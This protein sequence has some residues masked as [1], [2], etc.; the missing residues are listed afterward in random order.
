[1][2]GGARLAPR[3]VA[4]IP[5]RLASTRL[6]G[7]MLLSDTGKPLVQYA[8]KVAQ[9]CSMIEQVVVAAD[10]ASIVQA[11]VPFGTRCVMTRTDHPNGSS[12]LAEAAALLGLADDAIVV[13]VQGDEPDLPASTLEK[14]IEAL[15]ADDKS[16]VST[17]ACT[18][19]DA[20]EIGNPNI[21]KV[22]RGVTG[23]ALYFS[24]SAIP[25]VRNAST[26]ATTLRHIGLYVYRAGF[27]K[28]YVTMQPTALEQAESLE[29]LRILEHGEQIAVALCDEAAGLSGIDTREQ[30][31]AFVRREQARR[32]V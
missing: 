7:K 21:V 1:M 32:E 13:N 31:D 9:R 5:A 17:A 16:A 23:R 25:Y 4:I 22:V 6:P 14:T 3:I 15:L 18:L 2:S 30:Y 20:A 11:L 10:D 26:H 8:V 28:R 29:Q 24:R 12:R 27:L 19:H